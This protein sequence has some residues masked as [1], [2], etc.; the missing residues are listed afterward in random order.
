[1]TGSLKSTDIEECVRSVMSLYNAANACSVVRPA[2]KA[3]AYSLFFA[4]LRT[5][6]GVEADSPAATI[7]A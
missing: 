1:M 2:R 3:H 4:S 6:I 5:P 7:S